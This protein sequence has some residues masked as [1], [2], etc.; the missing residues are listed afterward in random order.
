MGIGFDSTLVRGETKFGYQTTSTTS[1]N[2]VSNN[3]PG[4]AYPSVVQTVTLSSESE[5]D[6]ASGTGAR[7]VTL[8]GFGS[9]FIEQSEN[10][11]TNGQTPVFSGLQWLRIPR[12]FVERCGS[13]DVN[14]GNIWAGYGTVTAGV[15]ENKMSEIDSLDGQTQQMH[16]TVPASHEFHIHAFI[17]TSGKVGGSDSVSTFQIRYR[18]RSDTDRPWRVIYTVDAL[19]GSIANNTDV[20]ALVIPGPADLEVLG[21]SSTAG[22]RLSCIIGYEVHKKLQD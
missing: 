6:T 8:T 18:D 9:G 7:R 22:A 17:L 4:P 11:W 21:K 5:T 3:G 12:M 2:V 15:P 20:D 14:A 10:I 19:D 1:Y 16:W 13:N